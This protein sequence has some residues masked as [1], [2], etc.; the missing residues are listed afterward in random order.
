MT[1]GSQL[2][3]WDSWT[4]LEVGFGA[5][6]WAGTDYEDSRRICKPGLVMYDTAG[7]GYTCY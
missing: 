6:F 2:S 1:I 4:L 3:E 5:G 7:L